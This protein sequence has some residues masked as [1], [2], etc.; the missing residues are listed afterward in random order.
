MPRLRRWR[1]SASATGLRREIH[2]T[3]GHSLTLL[4]VQLETAMQFEARGDP[5]LH[6]E[7]REARRVA[8]ACLADVRHSVEALRPDDASASSLQDGLRALA[9]EFAT[10]AV[11]DDQT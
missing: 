2:D 9:A 7:L 6:E 4:A 5:G 11:S 1:P 3:L 8:K 10:P